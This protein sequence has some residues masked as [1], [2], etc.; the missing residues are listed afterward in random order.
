MTAQRTVLNAKKQRLEAKGQ[1]GKL[2]R[3]EKDEEKLSEQ[4]R[5]IKSDESAL[6]ESCQ[7]RPEYRGDG[8]EVAKAR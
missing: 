7:L 6:I 2:A 8:D 4:E 3:L 1:R 5:Q